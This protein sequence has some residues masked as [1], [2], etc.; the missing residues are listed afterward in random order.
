MEALQLGRLEQ[1]DLVWRVAMQKDGDKQRGRLA[2]VGVIT[3]IWS[4]A[5]TNR[6]QIRETW[7]WTNTWISGKSRV[8][9]FFNFQ[10]YFWKSQEVI[11]LLLFVKCWDAALP[12]QQSFILCI[13]WIWMLRAFPPGHN[14]C[15]YT[16]A[17][18]LISSFWTRVWIK[19]G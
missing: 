5:E 13:A 11:Q 8:D 19:A 4:L 3:E 6:S 2:L 9:L 17:E 18:D 15:F 14:T 12:W 7:L 1:I 16:Q 10:S